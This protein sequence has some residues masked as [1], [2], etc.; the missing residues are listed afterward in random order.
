MAM[1][2]ALV[3]LVVPG[4][5]ICDPGCVAKTYPNFFRDLKNCCV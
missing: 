3:G 4:V 2:M 5:V 1:S